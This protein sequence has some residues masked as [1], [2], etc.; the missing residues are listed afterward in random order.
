LRSTA[1]RGAPPAGL[2]TGSSGRRTLRIITQNSIDS[3]STTTG[4]QEGSFANIRPPK[5]FPFPHCETFDEYSNPKE[6]GYLPRYTAD[7]ADAFE[8]TARPDQQGKRL[9]QVVSVPT[10]SWAPDWQPYTILG[11]D[12]WQDYEVSVAVCLN[13]GDSAAVLGRINQVGTG[14]GFI[15]KGYFLQL[16]TDG[17]C[18]LVVVSGKKDK[19]KP[20]GDIEQRALLKLQKDDGE[21]GERVLGSVQLPKP[22]L[23]HW[24]NLKLRFEGSTITGLV[25]DRPLLTATNGLYARGMA[26]LMA[27][28]GETKKLGTPYFDN[29]LINGIV[30]RPSSAMPGQLPIFPGGKDATLHVR[31]GCLTPLSA[32][33]RWD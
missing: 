9:R 32:D 30:P 7:S 19:T 15:P 28:A 21:G 20:I 27:G 22:S 13:P 3:L 26:G 23:N 4:Q 29:V 16:G 2:E 17:Q 24:H 14:Y 31:Q 11:D 1:R 18:Q 8:I 33:R 12:Q 10:I 25:D 6:Y 5:P